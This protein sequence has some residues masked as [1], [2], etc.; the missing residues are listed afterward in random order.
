MIL[1]NCR[2][3]AKGANSLFVGLYRNLFLKELVLDRNYIDGKKCKN[4]RDVLLSNECL[5]LLSMQQCS[6][7]DE[8]AHSLASGLKYNQTL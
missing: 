1:T 5:E 3:T 8:G 4:I 2:I 7:G 6:L